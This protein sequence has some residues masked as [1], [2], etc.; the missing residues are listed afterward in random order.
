ME[1]V[2]CFKGMQSIITH[3]AQLRKTANSYPRLLSYFTRQ[4]YFVVLTNPRTL[5]LNP[6]VKA[7]FKGKLEL[8]NYI[9]VC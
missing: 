3:K 7:H 9:V 6:R 1:N 8:F 4:R 5:K 2:N